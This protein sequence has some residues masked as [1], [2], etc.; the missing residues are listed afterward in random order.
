MNKTKQGLIQV[1][2]GN[3]KG[4][5]TAAFGLAMRAAGHGQKTVIIQFMKPKE[6]S[7]EVVAAKRLA[8]EITVYSFGREGFVEKATPRDVSLAKEALDK[9]KECLALPDLDMLILDEINN[10][11]YFQLVSL[12]EVL[13]LL[14]QKPAKIELVLTGRNAPKELLDAADLV[15]CM[16]EIK[17]PYNFKLPKRE[18]I[19]Y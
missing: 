12:A 9:A 8:P 14:A 18:G 3:G 5:T 7:G 10:A 16:E 15:T 17:H 2:T 11:L 13:E 4:K 19:E 1:Y 6:G